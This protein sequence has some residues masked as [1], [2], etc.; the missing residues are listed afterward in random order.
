[1]YVRLFL[2]TALRK[3]S[4]SSTKLKQKPQGKNSTFGRTFPPICKTQEI[5]KIHD[6]FASKLKIFKGVALSYHYYLANIFK[7]WK[8]CN[9]IVKILRFVWKTVIFYLNSREKLKTQGKNSTSWRTCPFPP[10]Q[11][12]LKK[13]DD[14][15]RRRLLYYSERRW[16]SSSTSSTSSTCSRWSRRRGSAFDDLRGAEREQRGWML[17]LLRPLRPLLPCHFSSASSPSSPALLLVL[18][19]LLSLKLCKLLACWQAAL[20][21]LLVTRDGTVVG[22][23]KRYKKEPPQEF[24]QF[25]VV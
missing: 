9:D 10:S 3:N 4:N 23:S 2:H 1:M 8:I 16:I 25:T 19:P 24:T 22:Y 6:I 11:V 5:I 21:Q 15:S 18:L 20:W 12:V 13:P 14:C 7:N 17:G